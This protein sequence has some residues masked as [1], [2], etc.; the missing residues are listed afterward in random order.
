MGL[1][2]NYKIFIYSSYSVFL[3][4]GSSQSITKKSFFPSKLIAVTFK[5]GYSYF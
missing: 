4:A 5:G 2:I 3:Q 1:I